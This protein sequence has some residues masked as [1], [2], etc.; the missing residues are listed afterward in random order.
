M[1]ELQ[2]QI[3]AGNKPRDMGK[4]FSGFVKNARTEP[5]ASP[6]P[7]ITVAD[8]FAARERGEAYDVQF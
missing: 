1:T 8:V 7:K 2:T 4:S 6:K 5:K 3:A